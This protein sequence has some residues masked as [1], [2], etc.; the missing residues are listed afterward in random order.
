MNRDNEPLVYCIRLNIG[1][2]FILV[3]LA[4]GI[5]TVVSRQRKYKRLPVM[6]PPIIL[7]KKCNSCEPKLH[8]LF[9]EAGHGFVL[10]VDYETANSSTRQLKNILIINNKSCTR[11]NKNVPS[12]QYAVCSSRQCFS[13]PLFT[14]VFDLSNK[15][16]K[17][18]KKN[19]RCSLITKRIYLLITL[20]T[21][22]VTIKHN[23]SYILQGPGLAR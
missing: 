12:I 10:V 21:F 19:G 7:P 15:Y 5:G 17:I 22:Q 6:K 2:C 20:I 18:Y 9:M 8:N 14:S 23:E 11:M 4:V 1:A 13:H 3:I 16:L